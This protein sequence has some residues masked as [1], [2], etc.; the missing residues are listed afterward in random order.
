MLFLTSLRGRRDRLAAA[1]LVLKASTP[2][3]REC[4]F[5]SIGLVE[6]SIAINLT[7]PIGKVS[8]SALLMALR[9]APRFA[10]GRANPENV[11]KFESVFALLS[12]LA[13]RALI[14]E[15]IGAVMTGELR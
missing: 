9:M 2:L 1:Q 12:R 13:A 8:L 14:M 15:M 6:E 11:R 10:A 4:V 3:A 7:H 5:R